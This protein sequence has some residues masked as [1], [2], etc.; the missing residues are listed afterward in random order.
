[1]S[2][3]AINPI[4]PGR[5]VLRIIGIKNRGF[6]MTGTPKITGSLILKRFGTSVIAFIDKI[7]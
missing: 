3:D 7:Y 6:N 2:L 1:M 4:T 5:S